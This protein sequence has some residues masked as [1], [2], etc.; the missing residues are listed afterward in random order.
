MGI[1]AEA[2]EGLTI[3]DVRS[4]RVANYKEQGLFRLKLVKP[5]GRHSNYQTEQQRNY[6]DQK[7]FL[8][9]PEPAT[10]N[11]HQ[12]GRLTTLNLEVTS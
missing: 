12:S 11:A 1:L 8:E 10:R 9:F 5:N 4:L 3:I 2:T 7:S 6:D